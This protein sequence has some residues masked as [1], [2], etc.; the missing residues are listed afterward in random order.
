MPR[1]G[2][3]TA[4]RRNTCTT[5]RP[6]KD[7]DILFFPKVWIEEPLAAKRLVEEDLL[8]CAVVAGKT[9]TSAPLSTRKERRW[10]RQKT[11]R[12]PSFGAAEERDEIAGDGDDVMPGVS[13][14]PRPR[15]FPR[16]MGLEEAS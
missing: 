16:Q 14:D 7:K 11:E 13:T 15:R 2:F 9:D 1:I 10:R 6:G 8:L 4:A 12:A 5:R 3:L